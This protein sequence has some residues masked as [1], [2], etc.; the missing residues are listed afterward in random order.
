MLC[1]FPA[2]SLF[3][4]IAIQPAPDTS[5]GPCINPLGINYSGLPKGW[6][7]LFRSA[8]AFKHESHPGMTVWFRGADGSHP[9]TC[10]IKAGTTAKTWTFHY[11]SHANVSHTAA[12]LSAALSFLTQKESWRFMY[13]SSSN[14]W[15]WSL[16]GYC[17]LRFLHLRD[18]FIH[19]SHS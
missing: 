14:P 1:H 13:I 9:T 4:G 12:T 11:L 3:E 5:F 16:V 2:I 6:E 10:I 15:F 8:V 7:L 19:K 17:L 18:V